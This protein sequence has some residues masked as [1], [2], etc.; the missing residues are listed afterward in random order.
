M[1]ALLLRNNHYLITLYINRKLR[2]LIMIISVSL[3][4]FNF[5][6]KIRKIR[7][8]CNI[9]TNGEV[10]MLFLSLLLTQSI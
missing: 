7:Q 9:L 1:L 8:F 4:V 3:D 5:I 6:L 2:N 10:I